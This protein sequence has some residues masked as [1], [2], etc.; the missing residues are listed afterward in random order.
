MEINML[1]KENHCFSCGEIGHFKRTCPK[2]STK[3]VNVHAV[4]LDLDPVEQQEI[5]SMWEEQHVVEN[6]E[7]APVQ[8]NDDDAQKDFY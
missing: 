2:G 3:K 1:Q 6:L 8:D 7:P 4:C 5:V